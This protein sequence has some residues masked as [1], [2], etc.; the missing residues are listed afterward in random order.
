VIQRA[1]FVRHLLWYHSMEPNNGLTSEQCSH[2]PSHSLET[3]S[4]P[5]TPSPKESEATTTVVTTSLPDVPQPPTPP[6]D[7]ADEEVP[8]EGLSEVQVNVLRRVMAGADISHAAVW[9]GVN[10]GTVHRWHKNPRF[11][12]VL[13]A[14]KQRTREVTRNQL[15]ALSERCVHVLSDALDRDDARVAMSLLKHLGML[16]PIEQPHVQITMTMPTPAVVQHS[17]PQEQ[18]AAQTEPRAEASDTPA[19]PSAPSNPALSYPSTPR[20]LKEVRA[21]INQIETKF[22]DMHRRPDILPTNRANK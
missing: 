14:W 3:S 11:A 19:P 2:G 10:R 12:A 5:L 8:L 20:T 18:R 15:V 21:L 1:E 7:E 17:Q 13:D 4:Q 9:A 6:R 16:T 22:D